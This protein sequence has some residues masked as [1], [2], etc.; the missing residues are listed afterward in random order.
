MALHAS[1]RNWTEA[2]GVG[3]FLWPGLHICVPELVFMF[4]LVKL[5]K[6]K[7]CLTITVCMFVYHQRRDLLC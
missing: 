7:F 6:S 3:R 4:V 5:Y 2:E 1:G